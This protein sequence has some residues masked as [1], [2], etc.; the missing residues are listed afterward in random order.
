MSTDSNEPH[1]SL[2]EHILELERLML[3][4]LGPV[5]P[6]PFLDVDVT[7]SQLKVLMTLAWSDPEEGRPG[8][9]MSDLS[10]YLGVTPPTVTVV[11][12][13][14]VER[15][16]V[17]RQLDAQ[18]RRQHRCELTP[19]GQEMLARVREASRLRTRRILSELT[20]T[21]LKVVEQAMELMIRAALRSAQQQSEVAS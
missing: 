17:E 20:H 7:M 18:D 15:G 11:V 6:N 1:A 19:E 10:R 16:L 14:L 8:L 3:R 21:E 13:R 5:E 9:R 2:I 12:D 4:A